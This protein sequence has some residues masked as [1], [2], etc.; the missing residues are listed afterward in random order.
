MPMPIP[1]VAVLV[2]GI[3]RRLFVGYANSSFHVILTSS[4]TRSHH[5]HRIGLASGIADV[6]LYLETLEPKDGQL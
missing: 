1:H 3:L 4:S 2:A 5:A 6:C